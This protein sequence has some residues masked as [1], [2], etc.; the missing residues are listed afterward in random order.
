MA[1]ITPDK[2]RILKLQQSAFNQT[3]SGYDIVLVPP[4]LQAVNCFLPESVRGFAGHFVNC[5]RQV[6]KGVVTPVC[7]TISHWNNWFLRYVEKPEGFWEAGGNSSIQRR[8][9][10]A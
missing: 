1:A 10:A 8:R 4:G 7:G 9:V 2:V 3:F 5:Q 6:Q